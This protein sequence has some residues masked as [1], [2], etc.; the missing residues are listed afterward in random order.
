MV[1]MGLLMLIGAL[2]A[3][4]D[5]STAGDNQIQLA[6]DSGPTADK[7]TSAERGRNASTAAELHDFS[8]NAKARGKR[9]VT[10][11]RMG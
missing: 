7:D 2:P 8:E 1:V 6:A 10:R 5:P 4:A 9:Q 3:A 11:P